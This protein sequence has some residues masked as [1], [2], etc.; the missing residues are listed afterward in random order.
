[1]NNTLSKTIYPELV[2][3]Y[4]TSSIP[5]LSA[6]TD[7]LNLTQQYID[8]VSTYIDYEIADSRCDFV[9]A[10]S[11][12][13]TTLNNSFSSF[14]NEFIEYWIKKYNNS[15][16]DIKQLVLSEIKTNNFYQDYSD[17]V[18]SLTNSIYT[19]TES[20]LP[21][22]DIDSSKYS[23]PLVYSAPINNKLSTNT[24]CLLSA[25]SQKTTYV[26]RKNIE[27]ILVQ[28]AI[29]TSAHGFNL[30]TDFQ[31]LVRMQSAIGGFTSILNNNFD[32]IFKLISFYANIN[33]NS[34]YNPNNSNYNLQQIAPLI[35]NVNVEGVT[36]Q[37]DLL[38]KKIKFIRDITTIQSVL[39]TNSTITQQAVNTTSIDVAYT[40]KSMSTQNT[41]PKE[42]D[43]ILPTN[44]SL[45]VN[46]YIINKPTITKGLVNT[47]V[48][49]PTVPGFNTSVPPIPYIPSKL[50]SFQ[51][52]DPITSVY[53]KT[54]QTLSSLFTTIKT[55]FVSLYHSISKALFNSNPDNKY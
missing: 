45:A 42:A 18:G 29:S 3:T 19:L 51:F 21:I 55:D 52:S 22:F 53:N 28:D 50:P 40:K 49:L 1:M 7:F 2:E 41:L 25:F 36:G 24:L 32:Q 9:S 17:S 33:N 6:Y 47:K 37:I 4:F 44:P 27:N 13:F 26:F 30:V 43:N 39:G 10:D 5:L 38:G 35:F 11:S 12:F 8:Q 14:D 34:G 20:V 31:H 48:L 15:V 16:N 46:K 23:Q 54:K